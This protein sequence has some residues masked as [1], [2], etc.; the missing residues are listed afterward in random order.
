MAGA[1]RPRGVL[2]PGRSLRHVGHD[3]H[4]HI[5]AGARRAAPFPHQPAWPAVRRGHRFLFAQGRSRRQRAVP[6]T[7]RIRLASPPPPHSPPPPP[8]PT[9]PHTRA[10]PP[11]PP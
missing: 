2:S 11:P 5:R 10:P 4:P 9:P 6:A 3:L 7:G 8:A 1:H